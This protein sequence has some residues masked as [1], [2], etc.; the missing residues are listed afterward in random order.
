MIFELD[1][2]DINY[3]DI[4]QGFKELCNNHGFVN[5]GI[6]G[7][8]STLDSISKCFKRNG[9]SLKDNDFYIWAAGGPNYKDES[10]WINKG[11]KLSELEEVT[12]TSNNDYT[13]SMQTSY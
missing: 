3:Y 5:V 11:F 13:V 10:K 9:N 6:Y 12:E 4:A 8:Y 7:N 2:S 1:S